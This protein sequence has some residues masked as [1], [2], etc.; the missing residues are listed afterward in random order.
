MDSARARKNDGHIVWAATFRQARI[1][2]QAVPQ[3]NNTRQSREKVWT[4]PAANV[5]AA[6]SRMSKA[7]TPST[8]RRAADARQ[9]GSA[10]QRA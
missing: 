5:I 9:D 4:R 1:P 3:A 2:I 6:K 10:S 7:T 8:L